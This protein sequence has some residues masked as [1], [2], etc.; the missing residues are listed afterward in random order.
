LPVSAPDAV[1]LLVSTGQSGRVSP[2][3]SAEATAEAEG[4][5]VGEAESLGEGDAVGESPAVA[6]GLSEGAAGDGLAAAPLGVALGATG[7]PLRGAGA[8][9]V[10]E[11]AVA[12]VLLG[13]GVLPGPVT[14]LGDAA[15]LGLGL[16][17]PAGL[18][19]VCWFW[20]PGS[21]IPVMPPR[22][23]PSRL[24]PCGAP[25]WVAAACTAC[26]VALVAACCW[27]APAG[28]AGLAAVTG[29]VAAAG[30][31]WPPPV[32]VPGCP[33]GPA[34]ADAWPPPVAAPDCP[35][36]PAGADA[37][38]PPVA[39]LGPPPVLRL[40][41]GPL[42]VAAGVPGPGSGVSELL[43]TG[44]TVVAG[45]AEGVQLAVLPAAA[46]ASSGAMVAAISSA[47]GTAAAPSSLARF[48]PRSRGAA[49][50]PEPRR[51]AG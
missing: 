10:G 36:A 37:W 2:F 39:A 8:A 42:A 46:W 30:A 29:L 24:W 9:G 15:A 51:R 45:V 41:A 20:W 23:V 11:L 17:L 21:K 3:A 50:R 43:G 31:D 25:G 35:D 1:S 18:G 13:A 22:I 6:P 19:G 4:V 26:R 12:G 32:A 14:P 49:C 5:P 40:P 44:V 34:G 28:A 47:V 16:G 48:R 27:A 38:P 33:D 7:A